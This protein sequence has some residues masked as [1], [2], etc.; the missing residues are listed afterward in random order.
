VPVRSDG[1]HATTAIATNG[2]KAMG[3]RL[4]RNPKRV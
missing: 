1:V 2:D 4:Q 3:Q